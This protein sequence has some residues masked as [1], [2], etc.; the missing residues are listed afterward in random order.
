MIRKL[1]LLALRAMATPAHAL[2]V[3]TPVAFTID[4][5]VT[6]SFTRFRFSP[7]IA[8]GQGCKLSNR[9]RAINFGFDDAWLREALKF[10]L[11]VGFRFSGCKFRVPRVTVLYVERP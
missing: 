11:K 1:A 8:D 10:R 2:D 7:T 5:V 6:G 9:G 4:Q 3:I